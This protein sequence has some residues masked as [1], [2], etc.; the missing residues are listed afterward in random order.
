MVVL[1]LIQEKLEGVEFLEINMV[2]SYMHLLY[3]F[4]KSPTIR[5]RYELLHME[6]NGLFGMVI[7]I[8]FLRLIQN[9]ST[10]D[11]Y[12]GIN[13]LVKYKGFYKNYKSLLTNVVTFHVCIFTGKPTVQKTYYPSIV[14]T[15][16]SS[17][18]IILI[19]NYHMIQKEVI[20]LRKWEYKASEEGN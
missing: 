5:Q 10:N 18:I 9:Y 1:C 12:V 15:N 3:L 20:F 7:R 2:T 14:I 6:C 17:N 19:I 4:E 8:S 16:T 13:L 11:F